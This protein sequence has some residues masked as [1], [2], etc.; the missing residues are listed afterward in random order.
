[1]LK[2]GKRRALSSRPA[3]E[4]APWATMVT[5]QLVLN[6]DGSLLT[7]FT[8]EGVDA[9]TPNA[10]DITAARNNLDNACK[11][12]DHRVTAWW[13]LSHRRVQGAIDGEFASSLDARLDA[14]N[15][16]NVGS[17]VGS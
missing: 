7:S 13:R 10:S 9:D 6:K 17:E 3:Q 11:N 15:R 16:E 1:M 5:P 4:I 8:F 2:P 14:I 12:F